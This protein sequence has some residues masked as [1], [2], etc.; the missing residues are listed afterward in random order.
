MREHFLKQINEN[1]TI[2]K[3]LLDKLVE[4]NYTSGK[5]KQVG[6]KPLYCFMVEIVDGN[7]VEMSLVSMSEDEISEYE[8]KYEVSLQHSNTKHLPTLIQ[9]TLLANG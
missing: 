7:D 6:D 8:K 5:L 3:E 4:K 9:K 2:T 1:K